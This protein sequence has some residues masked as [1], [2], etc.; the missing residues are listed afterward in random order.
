[1]EQKIFSFLLAFKEFKPHLL[2]ILAQVGYTFVYF[3]TEASFNHGMSPYVYVTY[4]H[5][6]AGVVMFPFAHFL[7]RYMSSSLQK[8]SSS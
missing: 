8:H 5:V 6:V 2:M 7:E 1:M 3:I 4:R